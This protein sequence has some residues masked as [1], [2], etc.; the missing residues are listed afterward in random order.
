[1]LTYSDNTAANII[2][3]K[4]GGVA[5][6]SDY[7][8]RNNYNQTV[9]QR[10]LGTPDINNDN[11]T[12]ALDCANYLD[13]LLKKKVVSPAASDKIIVALKSRRAYEDVNSDFFGQFLPDNLD[14]AHI[15]GILTNVRNDAG[16]YFNANKEPVIIVIMS[17]ELTNEKAGEEAISKGVESIFKAIP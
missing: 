10:K 17:P 2:I 13:A 5:T 7:A 12:S 4:L 11:M 3:D 16:F 1:M 9:L 15:S 8:K 14:Y 6:V